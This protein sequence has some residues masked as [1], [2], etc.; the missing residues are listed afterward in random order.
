MTGSQLN[1]LYHLIAGRTGAQ[2]FSISHRILKNRGELIVS[3]PGYEIN[4]PVTVNDL[5]GL[6]RHPA[7]KRVSV[8]SISEWFVIPKK[9]DTACIDLGKISFPLVIRKW[10]S[11]DYFYPFGMKGS[12]KV[13][14]YFTDRKFSLIDKG[15]TLLLESDG[16]IIWILGER[17][18]NRFRITSSTKKAL[19]LSVEK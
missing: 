16:K 12:K 15:N 14:D 8:V 11:G 2:L 18:D 13:S 1:D 17:L 6:R 4:G 19:I 10:H 3:E 7:F 9:K 5:K